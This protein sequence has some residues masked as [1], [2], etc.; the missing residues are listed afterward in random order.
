MFKRILI[1]NRGEIAVRV[2][3]ACRELGVETVAVYSEADRAALHVQYA[4]YAVFIG[5][6]PSAES[7]LVIPKIIDAAQKTGA[8]AIHPGYGFLS[9]RAAFARACREAGVVFI[10][11]SPVAIEKMGD[12]VTARTIM[13][14]A[15][16][17]VVPGTDVLG[18]E[19]EV[20]T[21]AEQIGFP[22]MFKASAG[23]GGKGMRLVHSRDEIT[24]ALRGVRSEAKSSFGDD[25]MYMEKFVEKPRHVEVQV[26]ADTY[27]HTIHLY[28]R[29]CS[30]QRRHQK[31]IEESPSLAINP[32]VREQ[33]G[34]VAVEAAKAVN[35]IGAGTVEFLVD[36]RQN[37]Y[38]L[39]MNTRIQVEHPVTE[40]VTGVDLVKAQIEIAAGEH[41]TLQQKDIQQRGWAIECRIYAEDPTRDFSPSP[42]R[43]E[44]LRTPG[45]NGIRDDS[46][47][48]EGW[49]VP[50][51]YD[52][53]ISKLCAY[54]RTRDEAI[55][56]M[57]RA[58]QEYTVEGIVTNIPF[59]R[60]ALKHPRF[61]AGDLD[62]GFIP[63]EFQGLPFDED[64]LHQEIILAAAALSAYHKDQ[65]LARTLPQG[66]GRTG[67]SAWR[68]GG[69]K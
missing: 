65:A 48:Y 32:A 21:A 24:S 23:G 52:P 16:V 33:M 39:E 61:V 38:F 28:E 41:L 34:R 17:P 54:G 44:I 15:D 45:G 51:Y 43:I 36:A 11:P 60:W 63:Q 6:S 5:P 68:T 8:E 66:S 20:I 3:R 53:M 1:A 57:L 26:L 59:H 37:F 7:Y 27:G 13:Q 14:K 40:L 2:I 18:S 67:M 64:H 29:E 22:V 4:D 25:R 35:Y 9:E 49:D 47:V 58:L 50:I 56:R 10:G 62:T 31:V 55:Q 19:D 46:G 12:K 42:G 30:L 69:W